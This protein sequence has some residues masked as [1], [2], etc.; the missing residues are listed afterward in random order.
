MPKTKNRPTTYAD[1][2]ALPPDVVGEIL[3]GVLHTHPRLRRGIQVRGQRH[4]PAV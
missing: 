2:E 1:I 3:F 4:C